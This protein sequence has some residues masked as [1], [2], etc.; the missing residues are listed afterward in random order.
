MPSMPKEDIIKEIVVEAQ[1]MPYGKQFVRYISKAN[2]TDIDAD[3]WAISEVDAYLD[4]WDKQG[5]KLFQTHY[6]GEDQ[7]SYGMFYILTRE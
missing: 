3:I 1:K 6:L 4:A 7:A 5:Y 2:I